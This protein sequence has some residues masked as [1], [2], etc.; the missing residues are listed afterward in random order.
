MGYRVCM[1]NKT[2]RNGNYRDPYLTA[3][4]REASAG[5]SVVDGYRGPFFLGGYVEDARWMHLLRSG[6][7]SALCA[8]WFPFE[9]SD[10]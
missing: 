7:G 4:V 9:A 3:L 5:R 1:L 6:T 10:A 8:G 2:Q